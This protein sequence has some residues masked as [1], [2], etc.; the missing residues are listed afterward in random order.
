MDGHIGVDRK[1][2]LFANVHFLSANGISGCDNLTIEI[3]QTHFVV[4]N[5]VQLADS[6]PRQRLH[7][8]SAHASDAEDRYATSVQ[9]L[10][11]FC[12]HNKFHPRKLIHYCLLLIFC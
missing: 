8:V 10:Q 11:G 7:H 4:I 5:N 12:S 2:A 6:A 9:N 1:D 3:G